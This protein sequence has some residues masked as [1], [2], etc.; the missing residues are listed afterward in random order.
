MAK[1]A[2]GSVRPGQ[3]R[4]LDRR[5]TTSAAAAPQPAGLSD[6]E[7]ARA[8]ELEQQLLA[9]ERAAE[10]ARKRTVERSVTREV[11]GTRTLAFEEEYAYVTRD[12][13]DIGRIAILLFAV[14]FLLYIVID[15][16]DVV[17]IG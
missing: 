1:R 7:L 8:D 3:R 11:A 2:R 5:P 4:S 12:L 10:T 17:K 15:V 6:A 13:K 9:E 16:M 14:L